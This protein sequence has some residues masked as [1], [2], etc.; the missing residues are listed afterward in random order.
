MTRFST[1]CLLPL[2]IL[3]C[4]FCAQEEVLPPEAK[5]EANKTTGLTTDIFEFSAK[6][7][8]NSNKDSKTYYRWDYGTDSKWNTL[9]S[10]NPETTF[11]YKAPGVY[12]LRLWALNSEGLSDSTSLDINVEQGASAPFAFFDILP[13]EGHIFTNYVFDASD[14]FDDEDSLNALK[15][16]WDFHSDGIWETDFSGNPVSSHTF[17]QENTYM[18]TLEVKD[19]G[20]L[21]T[22]LR[23]ELKVGLIDPEL[24][25][26]FKWT[27]ED[28]TNLDTIRF[29]ASDS[30]HPI[31]PDMKLQYRWLFEEGSNWTEYS[32]Q[33]FIDYKFGTTRMQNVRLMVMEKR[34]VYNTARK[35]IYLEQANRPPSAHFTLSIPNGN[36]KTQ[37]FMDAWT[38]SDKEDLPTELRIRWDFNS[39]GN[40]DTD[41]SNEKKVFHQFTNAGEFLITMEVKDQQGLTDQFS[42]PVKVSPFSNETGLIIDGRDQEIYGTVKIG[43]QW[44]MAENLKFEVA[45]KM[46]YNDRGFIFWSPWEPWKCLQEHEP[47][48][49]LYGKFYHIESGID[50]THI[51]GEIE[52]GLEVNY[53]LCPR[54]WRM[55]YKQDLLELLNNVGTDGAAR[56]APGGDTD[57]N[58]Q[59]LGV[60]DFYITWSSMMVPEDTI[61]VYKHTY[62]QAWLFSQ[63]EADN[64][65]R[66]DVYAIKITKSQDEIWRG[67]EST[68]YFVP[69]RCIKDE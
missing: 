61:Y 40:W 10:K 30:H 37:F 29:D 50:N 44:W 31:Y 36:I 57:F 62:E 35:E 39:D 58:L 6:R 26:D 53:E 66:T 4:T 67:E 14:T 54:G 59:H 25:V 68:R 21:S 41:Y 2:I 48:C 56:L 46:Y 9:P 52:D 60:I 42:L 33:P 32:D 43:N 45:R 69:I 11:R 51:R 16:R 63:E 15:F 23:K 12:T 65:Y 13:L 47:Y 55:P 22:F 19:P 5:I 8:S 28:A 34:G 3:T 18:V 17:W 64:Q 49:D 27:P 38:S 24:I 7:T 1:Y 20:G